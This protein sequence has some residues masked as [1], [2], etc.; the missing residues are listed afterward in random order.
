M[1]SNDRRTAF[2]FGSNLLGLVYGSIEG[3]GGK[4]TGD[5]LGGMDERTRGGP[6]GQVEEGGLGVFQRGV[7]EGRVTGESNI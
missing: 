4:D 6:N 3:W 1:L 7:I 5:E 2:G